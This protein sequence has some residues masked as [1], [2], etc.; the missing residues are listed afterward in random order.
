MNIVRNLVQV[1]L[2]TIQV[3]LALLALFEGG[4]KW[5]ERLLAGFGFNR[6]FRA[7]RWL[8]ISAVVLALALG[9]RLSLP[10]AA[11]YY[12]N[13]AARAVERR[14]ITAA[15]YDYRRALSFDADYA[16]ARYG[17]A[18]AYEDLHK[19]DEAIDEYSK[20]II[21]DFQFLQ[22]HNNLARLLLKRGENK[23]YHNALQVLNNALDHSPRDE[24]LE[25]SLYK[26][27]GWANYELK[28]YQQAENDLRAAVTRRKDGAAAHCLLGYLLEAQGKRGAEDEWF[29][30]VA[31]TPGQETEVEASWFSY[32]QEKMRER[33]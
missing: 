12:N 15:V 21:L 9:A 4:R 1:P 14:D 7:A 33:G 20:A 2:L 5:V 10:L 23:D 27:R 26:N 17:L 6:N 28:N 25:Y 24:Y 3:A 19:Y 30:C 13:R 8:V 22:A 16:Q 11:R 32:A 31:Y 29:D 18:V